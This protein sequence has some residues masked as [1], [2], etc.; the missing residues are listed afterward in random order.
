MSIPTAPLGFECHGYYNTGSYASPVWVEI[1]TLRDVTLN[2]ERAKIDTSIRGDGAYKSS[3]SG[4][5]D[6][7]IDAEMEY[8]PTDASFSVLQGDFFNRTQQEF[9]FLDG[10]STASSGAQGIRVFCEITK[11]NRKEPLDGNDTIEMT[12]VRAYSTAYTTGWATQ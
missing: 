3:R 4:M 6:I 2:L 5:M 7:S 11:F 12:L 9:I 8:I 1:K 10:V